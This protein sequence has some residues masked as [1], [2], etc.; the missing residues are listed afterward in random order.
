LI[1]P[2]RSSAGIVKGNVQMDAEMDK[3]FGE[4]LDYVRAEGRV[5]STPMKWNELW[6]MLPERPRVGA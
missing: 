6:E 3:K 4:L 5:C 2:H 1:Q